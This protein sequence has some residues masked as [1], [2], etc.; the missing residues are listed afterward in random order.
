MRIKPNLLSLIYLFAF[1]LPFCA[2]GSA[3]AVP[4]LEQWLSPNLGQ[5]KPSLRYEGSY[6]PASDLENQKTDMGISLHEL[7]GTMP[8]YQTKSDEIVLLA[9]A[10]YASI[11]TEAILPDSGRNF[12]GNFWNLNAALSYRHSMGEGW[13][14]GAM[15]GLGSPS[16]KPFH[17]SDEMDVNFTGFLRVP[18]GPRNAW[19]FL[20]NYTNNRDFLSGAPL[21]GLAYLYHPNHKFRMILGAPLFAL[22]YDPT[23][24][25][26]VSLYY[27]YPRNVDARLTWHAAHWL[28]FYIGFDWS[29]YRYYLADRSHR[30]N[31]LF[32]FQ[33]RGFIGSNVVLGGGLIL[34]LETGCSFD[35]LFFE[36]ENYGDRHQERIDL[37]N[38][39]LAAIRLGVKF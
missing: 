2:A 21:P 5:L 34:T 8:L 37:E 31:R 14:W 33:K 6:Y 35:R 22:K 24:N 9:K 12:P 1:S 10:A 4:R 25:W 16:N 19:L 11:A 28:H 38:S 13:L 23:R 29:N 7:S 3:Q 20:L 17:S 32:Y 36:G 30:E 27:M 15:A 39:W 18:H 26:T